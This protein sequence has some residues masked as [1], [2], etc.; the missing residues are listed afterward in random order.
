MGM[1]TCSAGKKAA[2]VSVLTTYQKNVE[3]FAKYNFPK[4]IKLIK[5]N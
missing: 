1:K 4:N 3:N 5:D 2:V